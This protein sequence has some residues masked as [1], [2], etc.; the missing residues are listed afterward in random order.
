MGISKYSR[1][2]EAILA[3]LHSTTSHPTADMVYT[4]VR[5]QYPNIS[6]GTVYRNLNQLAE[7]GVILRLTNLDGCDHYDGTTTPHYHFLCRE[8]KQISDLNMVDSLEHICTLASVNFGGKIEG[9]ITS[10]HGVCPNCV[11]NL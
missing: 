8:C 6:L 9:H 11:N 2:R 4:V 3:Y 10:F 5:E 1:Q 7:Q